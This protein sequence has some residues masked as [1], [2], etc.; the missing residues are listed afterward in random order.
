MGAIL[1]KEKS[2]TFTVK[3][4]KELILKLDKFK[5]EQSNSLE[6]LFKDEKDYQKFLTRLIKMLLK[7]MIFINIKVMFL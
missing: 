3:Q 1:D 7:K 5:E 2:D 6:A 4:L